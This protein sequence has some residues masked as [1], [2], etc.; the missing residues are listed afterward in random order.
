MTLAKGKVSVMQLLRSIGMRMRE[1]PRLMTGMLMTLSVLHNLRGLVGE[2][3]FCSSCR[4]LTIELFLTGGGA[5]RV[6]VGPS[7]EGLG[8]ASSHGMAVVCLSGTR[9]GLNQVFGLV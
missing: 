1:S 4:H 3:G 8:E 5:V 9:D 6:V 7:G 2:A